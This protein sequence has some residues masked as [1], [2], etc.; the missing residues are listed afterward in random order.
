MGKKG[1][2]IKIRRSRTP[3]SLVIRRSRTPPSVVVTRTYPDNVKVHTAKDSNGIW[4]VIL[5][6]IIMLGLWSL[7]SYEV[8]IKI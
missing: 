5:I 2:T 8:K 6:I 7:S 3:P 1:A 4:V